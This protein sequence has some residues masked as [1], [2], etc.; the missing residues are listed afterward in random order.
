MF[1]VNEQ[2]WGAVLNGVA[3]GHID[4]PVTMIRRLLEARRLLDDDVTSPQHT[5]AQNHQEASQDQLREAVQEGLSDLANSLSR[6]LRH[7]P[8][9]YESLNHS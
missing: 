4:N 9:L 7:L 3:N 2:I 6:E 8:T 1:T 5:E